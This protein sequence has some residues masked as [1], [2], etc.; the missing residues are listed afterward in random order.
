VPFRYRLFLVLPPMSSFYSALF[1]STRC[2]GRLSSSLSHT[3]TSTYGKPCLFFSEASAP[4]SLRRIVFAG[5]LPP[6]RFFLFAAVAQVLW[7]T[8]LRLII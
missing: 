5:P 6:G 1:L 3:L 2:A 4:L 8:A 7:P